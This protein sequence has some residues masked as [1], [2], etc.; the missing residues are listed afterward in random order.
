MQIPS[1][2]LLLHLLWHNIKVRCS[3]QYLHFHTP[4][5]GVS[6]QY[7][8][9]NMPLTH[10]QGRISMYELK[11]F[12]LDNP[13]YDFILIT[14]AGTP[15]TIALSGMSDNTTEPAPIVTL[16]PIFTGPKI[17]TFVAI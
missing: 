1:H 16:F 9:I 14:L 7:H 4:S 6:A 11:I 13:L 12:S 8:Y 2:G 17:V 5:A 10:R 3:C 15:A